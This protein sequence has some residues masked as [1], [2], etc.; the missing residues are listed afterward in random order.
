MRKR[1]RHVR[2]YRKIMRTKYHRLPVIVSFRIHAGQHCLAGRQMAFTEQ[3]TENDGWRNVISGRTRK[4]VCRAII[5]PERVWPFK[6]RETVCSR[7]PFERGWILEKIRATD[8]LPKSEIRWCIRT[9]TIYFRKILEPPKVQWTRFKGRAAIPDHPVES[10]AK[11]GK[12]KRA[13]LK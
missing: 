9:W 1:E 11:D 8:R 4:Y 6:N 2:L 5:K 3:V 13:G 10:F 7:G 12:N